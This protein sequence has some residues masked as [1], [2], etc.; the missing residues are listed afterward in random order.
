MEMRS[1]GRLSQKKYYGKK[2]VNKNGKVSELFSVEHVEG[3]LGNKTQ[4]V[5][6]EDLDRPA[7]LAKCVSIFER[8]IIYSKSDWATGVSMSALENT[9]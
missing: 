8:D 7:P 9:G 3:R 2:Y 6:T 5:R 4:K 1:Q